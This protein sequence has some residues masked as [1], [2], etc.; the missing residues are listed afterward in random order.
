MLTTA[1]TQNTR[2]IVQPADSRAADLAQSLRISNLTA[3]VLLNRGLDG[4]ESAN[5]FLRPKLVDL[6]RPELMPGMPT[7]VERVRRAMDR[8][9]KITV[10]G[11][12]DVDGITGVSILLSLLTR[13]G[14]QVDYYIP[15]RLDEG[16][17]LN[18]EAVR[19]IAAAGTKLLVTV[20]C[21]IGAAASVELASQLGMDVI[22]TDHHE[23][24]DV[25]PKALTIVHPRLAAG[26]SDRV[27]YANPDSAG[28]MVAFKLAWAVANTFS[29]GPRMAGDLRQ[30]MLDATSLAALG[31]VAD[32]VDLCGE[33]RVLT[34][35][36][37]KALPQSSL[38]GVQALIE[39]AGLAGKGL[40]S[41]DVGFKLGPMLNAAGR[42]GHARLAVELLTAG[43]AGR[44][45]QIAEYL[46][47]QNTLRQQCGQ[48]IF[49]EACQLILAQGLNHPDR[50]SIVLVGE[51]W[52]RGVLGI[53]AARIVDRFNRPTIVLN[54]EDG[55]EGQ[56]QGSG[57]SIP[58]FCL[59]SAIRSCSEHLVTFGGHTM[60]AGLTVD[61]GKVPA[62]SEAFEAYAGD[63]LKGE[64]VTASL[65]IDALSP[66]VQFTPALVRQLDLLGP[67]GQGNPSPVF[68][69]RGVRWISPPRRVG[70]REDHLQVAVTDNTGSIRCVGFNM[71]K[72]EK[73]LLE[74]DSF[75]IAYQAQ[76]NTYNGNTSVEFILQDVQ[77]E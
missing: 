19:S 32:V 39:C 4:A 12:Y 6:I 47:E 40:D 65:R 71:G 42:M 62:F 45:R 75:N 14:G 58:G 25:L 49:K 68:A 76:L 21:G 1:G 46:K 37:L 7:A 17:G 16:Y 57:R 20:D 23:P 48:K 70:V 11:D 3:Q 51:N 22:I 41:Y 36:G 77:F 61:A 52:H 43:S 28:A 54:L 8:G 69:T 60:A 29:T 15:H 59:L 5:T 63:N 66:L 24:G 53:V 38:A 50:R 64:D 9:E 31:T 30:F 56:A 74:V 55:P 13:L 35:Y 72:I 34:H 10:Y 44:C 2:W 67:F 33:N 27:A 18:D 26:V 73:R